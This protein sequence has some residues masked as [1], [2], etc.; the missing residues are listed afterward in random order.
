MKQ[1][2]TYVAL[3]STCFGFAQNTIFEKK[4]EEKQLVNPQFSNENKK[5]YF[6]INNPPSY[7]FNDLIA[8]DE[9]G[10]VEEIFKSQKFV[11]VYFSKESGVYRMLN[12]GNT[13]T[14]GN[15]EKIS[16]QLKM[17]NLNN[18]EELN[19][20]FN[21]THEVFFTNKKGKEINLLQ[22]EIYV[23]EL[24]VTTGAKSN[25]LLKAPDINR[26]TG[27]SF[28]KSKKIGL[29]GSVKKDHFE[30]ITK[31]ISSDY[32]KNVIYKSLYDFQG[33]P[34]GEVIYEIDL[35]DKF[36]ITSTNGGGYTESYGQSNRTIFS[37]DL[38]I[39]NFYEDGTN[40]D[41]YVYGIYSDK[42]SELNKTVKVNGYY[43][44]KFGKNG[45]K[46]WE[47]V[48]NFEDEGD[49]NKPY[50]PAQI[51][52]SLAEFKENLYFS[53]AVNDHKEFMHYAIL[54]KA[55]GT[56]NKKNKMLFS[57][58]TFSSFSTARK[59]LSKLDGFTNL[60]N[61]TFDDN[62]I[63]AV[64]NNE[65]LKKYIND[66]QVEK[67]NEIHYVSSFINNKIWVVA[68]DNKRYFKVTTF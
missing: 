40:G 63:I 56:V 5:L 44:F 21:G 60:K 68:Y 10:K 6:S 30:I 53:L 19:Q 7:Y 15:S 24:S 47:S 48:N 67:G 31:S 23:N 12:E 9:T 51:N 46:I 39:N 16:G 27:P 54:D 34:L 66:Q 26:L 49:L 52:T 18:R 13:Y 20:N 11:T 42:A 41:F 3:I 35:K 43:V 64:D 57:E 65:A 14:I 32:H 17:T 58:S 22:D 33:K 61:K 1:F 38:S 55:A 59:F 36:L 2:L 25:F 4:F 37:D 29:K 62:T 50:S 28:I 45:N 8:V